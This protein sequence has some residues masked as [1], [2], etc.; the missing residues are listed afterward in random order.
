MPAAIEDIFGG[1]ELAFLFGCY[2]YIAHG[3]GG[4][5]TGYAP[6]DGAALCAKPLDKLGIYNKNTL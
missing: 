4:G 2:V 5:Y 6:Q 3:R 1:S